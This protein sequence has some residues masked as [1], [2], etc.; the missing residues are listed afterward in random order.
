MSTARAVP[1]TAGSPGD[2][3]LAV[4]RRT[5]RG[6]LLSDSISRMRYADGFS[7]SRAMAFQ[8]VL[9]LVPASIAFVALASVLKW[10][11]MSR[12]VLQTTENVSPGTTS[13]VFREAFEQGLGRTGSAL[14]ALTVGTIAALIA[15]TTAYGQLERTANRIYGVEVDRPSR[16]KYELAAV[17]FAV[18]ALLVLLVLLGVGALEDWR[19]AHDGG[20]ETFS[21]AVTWPL[22][23]AALLGAF[24][25]IFSVCPRRRQ[26]GA[27]WVAFGALVSMVCFAVV[28][29]A[30]TLYL[31]ASGSFGDTYG[32]LAGLMGVLL[33]A[34]GIAVA[35]FLGVAVAAQLEAVR[36]GVAE[37][38]DLDKAELGEP[39]AVTVPYGASLSYSQSAAESSPDASPAASQEAGR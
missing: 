24:V 18:T 33:W 2:G 29:V 19:L 27:R 3:P 1:E 30:L 35:V 32:P 15:G 16:N 20:W 26:P 31:D 37:P 9:T 8:V 7:H 5:D 6:Q 39:D 38:R 13:E 36:A 14:T 22:G 17:M 4:L 21:R 11:S 34:Y 10:E 23:G 12:A 25:V 28:T